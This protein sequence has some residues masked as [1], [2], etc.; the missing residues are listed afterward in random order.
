MFGLAVE[1]GIISAVLNK[2]V[3]MILVGPLQQ[4]ATS[5]FLTYITE[6][7]GVVPVAFFAV[8]WGIVYCHLRATKDA[9]S[10]SLAS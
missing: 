4:S 3:A 6:L 10:A 5:S 7:V 8:A 2:I 1:F 9:S